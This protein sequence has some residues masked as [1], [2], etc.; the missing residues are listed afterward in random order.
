MIDRRPTADDLTADDLVQLTG[1]LDPPLVVVTVAVGEE[2]S[3]CVVGFSTQCS[4]D[5]PRYAI[6]LSRKNRTYRVA[7]GASHLAVHFLTDAD[8][9]LAELFGGETDD[10][11]DKFARCAWRPGDGGVPLL[12]A[13]PNRFVG[14][15]VATLDEGGDHLGVVLEPFVLSSGGPFRPLRHSRVDGLEPGHQP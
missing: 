8:L 15:V 6:W 5:P 13:C 7:R 1:P 12:D 2:R 10:E 3:G 4:M 14:R 9:E 11:I